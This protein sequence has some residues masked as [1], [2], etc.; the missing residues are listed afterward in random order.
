MANSLSNHFVWAVVVVAT[1]TTLHHCRH[2]R[3]ALAT[4][5][6]FRPSYEY[7]QFSWN[8]ELMSPSRARVWLHFSSEE[9]CHLVPLL[10]INEVLWCEKINPDPEMALCVVLAHLSYPGR[11]V[12]LQDMFGKSDTW[13]SLVFN[14]VYYGPRLQ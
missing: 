14:S 10:W 6:T 5:Q 8:L 3:K 7:P 1:T 9:I 4:R 2:H 11:W 12:T 13:L